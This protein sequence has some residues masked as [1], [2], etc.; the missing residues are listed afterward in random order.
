MIGPALDDR[1]RLW[2]VDAQQAEQRDHALGDGEPGDEPEHRAEQADHEPFEP[3]RAHDLLARGAEGP[4]GG[5]L[6]RALGDRDRQR[7]EDHERADQ[8]RDAAEAEQDHPDRVHAVVDVLGVLLRLLGAVLDLDVRG[9]ERLDG[10]D[11]LGRRGAGLR[12]DRDRVV[13]ALAVEDLLRGLDV[14]DGD[15]AEAERVDLAV[16][17]R[18]G[19]LVAVLPGG[20]VDDD[21]VAEL[22]VLLV[23]RPGVDHDLIAAV[24]PGA[25]LEVERAEPRVVLVVAGADALLGD[26]LAVLADDVGAVDL[27]RH[28]QAAGGLDLGLRPDLVEERGGQCDAAAVGGVLDDLLALDDGVGLLVRRI[29][30]PGEGLLHRVG[31]DERAADHRD[32]DD[33]GERGEQRAD[34]ATRESLQR[35]RPH[36]PLTC[37][38]VS[39][40]S[41]AVERP[42]SRT[43]SPSA[44]KST[45]SAIAAACASWVTMTVV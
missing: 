38:S 23:R 22:V 17:R 7:V 19:D 9:D 4:Q 2:E 5:E 32:A 25:G 43:M 40:I 37:S 41:C 14:P 1:R 44:R 35:N 18:A 15:A 30:E 39:R 42:R 20:G 26:G 8:Q 6:T 31:E 10:L 16:A 29:E 21:G 13:A 28:D 27:V 11:Q 3:H 45:R 12:G 36:R 34:L 33:D 24:G